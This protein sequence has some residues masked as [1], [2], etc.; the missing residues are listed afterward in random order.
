MYKTSWSTYQIGKRIIQVKYLAMPNLLAD[1]PVF[2]EFIQDAATPE[3]IADAAIELLRSPERRSQ[4]RSRLEQIVTSLGA[5]GAST[6]AA[7][8]ILELLNDRGVQS[9]TKPER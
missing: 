6:R 5:P 4:I 2:P 8:A 9:G 7:R 3:N 1:E